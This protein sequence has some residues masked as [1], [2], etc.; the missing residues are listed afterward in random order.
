MVLLWTAVCGLRLVIH[1][2]VVIK[3]IIL[4]TV[5]SQ[6]VISSK[7]YWYK[8]DYIKIDR[9]NIKNAF[10]LFNLLRIDELKF[11]YN[12]NNFKWNNVI[13][14]ILFSDLFFMIFGY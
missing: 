14:V 2:S 11:L 7:Q 12:V 9:P 1:E 4:T 6:T 10:L 3:L 13:C 5:I 8:T